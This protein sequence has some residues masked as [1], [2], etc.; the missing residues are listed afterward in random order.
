[1]ID[2]A[3]W[4]WRVDGRSVR[5]DPDTDS[6]MR[7]EELAVSE[8][9]WW[10]DWPSA[11]LADEVADDAH[12]RGAVVIDLDSL[13]T[14]R[15]WAVRRQPVCGKRPGAADGPWALEANAG[16][17]PTARRAS[18]VAR[19][20]TAR[21]RWSWRRRAAGLIIAVGAWSVSDGT[22]V[23]GLMR[24]R[25]Q[26]AER[27]LRFSPMIAVTG[28]RRPGARLPRYSGEERHTMTIPTRQPTDAKRSSARRS[29]H[30]RIHRHA[31]IVK[32]SAFR[33]STGHIM[34]GHGIWFDDSSIEVWRSPRATS[35]A[36]PGYPRIL[37][38]G[39]GRSIRSTTCTRRRSRSTAL[40]ARAGLE[41]SGLWLHR[42]GTGVPLR[43]T[44]AA[45]CPFAAST[46]LDVS[47]YS[48]RRQ[49][50]NA[51]QAGTTWRRRTETAGQHEIDFHRRRAAHGDTTSRPSPGNGLYCLYA[52][53]SP[54]SPA[55]AC[56]HQSLTDKATGKTL[57]GHQRR[58][59]RPEQAGLAPSPANWPTRSWP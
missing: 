25:P 54:A 19:P 51:L 48:V 24:L 58:Q 23:R 13:T 37:G 16:D 22:A 26:P 21:W 38:G 45:C 3:P 50:V 14:T 42:P 49:M 35:G 29:V 47:T 53:P 34:R 43:L 18:E 40:R 46:G 1:M 39:N 7:S 12:R 52:K 57:C 30:Q 11:S 6:P 2:E 28:N 10:W 5:R 44:P 33:W 20:R 59:R 32:R 9:R 55:L 36:R 8:K 17:R 15:C 31:G 27:R 41:S 56:V 4:H